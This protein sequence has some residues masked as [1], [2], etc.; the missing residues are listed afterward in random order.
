VLESDSPTGPFTRV[1]ANLGKGIDGSVFIEDNGDWFFYHTG[2]NNIRGNPM[3]T[4]TSMGTDFNAGVTV[5]NAWT[6]GPTV[7]KRNGVYYLIYTGNHVISK[8][9]R[10]DYA[11]SA[12][13]PQSFSAQSDQ[14]PILLNS[15]GTHVGLGHGSA[16]IGPDLDTYYYTYHNLVSGSGP[17]RQLNFDRMAWNGDKLLLLGP[18]TW[19]QQAFRQADM[20]DFFDRT[21]PGANWLTP[22]GGNWTIVA[23]DRLVQA[24]QSNT[25]FY[26]AIYNQST[27]TDYIAEFT[28]K[29][30]ARS[31]NNARFGAIFSYS[32]EENYG[33]AVLNSNSNHLEINFKQNNSWG[34]PLY[35]TLPT[36][37]DLT[38]WH[39]LRME[40]A[41]T[42]YT[43]FID[44]MQKAAVT[45]T[46]ESG[47]IGYATSL[48]QAG[49]GYIAFSNQVNGSSMFDIYKP[50]PGII[51]AVHYNSG[52]EG[53]AYH[54]LTPGNSG[55]GYIRNDNVDVNTC[56][57]GGFAINSEGGEWYKYNV[58]VKT[59]GLYHLGLR[60]T[61]TG[62]TRVRV[63][64]EDTALTDEIVLPVTVQNT[65]RT[66]TIKDL[67]LPAGYQTLK[68]ETVSGN[69]QFYEMYFKEADASE[70]TLIDA[71]DT[72]F[73]SSEWNY[74]DGTW[75]IASGEAEINGYGK[76]T[77]GNTGWTDYT[78]QVDMT[79]V[80][81]VNAGIIFRATN[82][83]LGEAGNSPQA[84]TD[85][86]QGYFVGLVSNGVVLGKQN[87]NWTQLASKTGESYLVN[88]KYT[89]KVETKDNNI[90]VYVD[91]VL[92]IDYNDPR[93][94]ICGKVGLRVCDTRVRFDNFRVT[95]KNTPYI[96]VTGISL[97]KNEITLKLN[98][99]DTLTA[100]IEPSN[101]DYQEVKWKS[102]D[103]AV[104]AVS[105][106]GIV[107]AR[108]LG[109]A[110]I[111]AT[112]TEG[113]F[114][115]D[116]AVTVEPPTGIAERG[117][118]AS[119][120]VY[121]N[122]TDG[123]LTL[124]FETV[125][126]RLVTLSDRSGK[127]LLRKTVNTQTAQMDVTHYPAD[128]YLLTIDDG[129][130]KSTMTILKK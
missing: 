119:Q 7:I 28:M 17:Q 94:F 118:G 35:C 12:A 128:V 88:T 68:I 126:R 8:G 78:V 123:R 92:K 42:N 95:T 9:Y 96:P 27:E 36:G 44:G 54:D 85:F 37:Y 55:G 69:Y 21:E 43:F 63:R 93:P 49:F 46:L 114:T 89:L 15:E 50:L 16:F 129:K 120:Q 97:D 116:C 31:S 66:Y 117:L 99:R 48:C 105:N 106:A 5:N 14:N 109:T 25:D 56:S 64:H 100:F 75:S 47:K 62:N 82:P 108:T 39:T 11:K 29:E 13:G 51:A 6:E 127:I 40:K 59:A 124:Q 26:K 122:P 125:G 84:G 101:A 60:Y 76:R 57:E 102:S 20:S 19:A 87:Y 73:F 34:T 2:S 24:Q 90:K 83:A 30:E 4:P 61:S 18:T 86:L 70:T 107:L 80:S 3:P 52:G 104:A 79:C 110:I 72:S 33:I 77:M 103:V 71:F 1:T 98:E 45:N 65:W 121:P 53:I 23:G 10:I 67:N 58:N 38:A 32:D 41:G 113:G 130:Q 74:A 22:N 111:T 81:G 112:S 115:A 91:G